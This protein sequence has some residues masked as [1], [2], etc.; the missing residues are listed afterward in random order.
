MDR[1]GK[2]PKAATGPRDGERSDVKAKAR[3]GL[4]ASA[5]TA[6]AEGPDRPGRAGAKPKPSKSA[7]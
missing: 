7:P 4:G 5:P 1:N 3:A 2:K 6:R